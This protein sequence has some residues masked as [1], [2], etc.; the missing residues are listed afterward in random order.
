MNQ[1]EKQKGKKK[2]KRREKWETKEKQA[3]KR[4]KK[5]IEWNKEHKTKGRGEDSGRPSYE[6]L[7]TLTFSKNLS[8][9]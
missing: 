5:E 8:H 9:I 4:N 6:D 2:K 7:K 3:P 1:R